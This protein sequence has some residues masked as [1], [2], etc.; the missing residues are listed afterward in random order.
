MSD[1]GTELARLMAAR[2]VGVRELAR[3]VPCNPGHISNLRSG[4][5]RP[6][7]E[8][9][10]ALDERLEA[11]GSL[12]ALVPAHERR[13][14]QSTASWDDGAAA[15]EIAALELGRLA[16]AT[17]VGTGTVER[18]ELAV[19][20][21]AIAYP[22]T[23]SAELYG[24]VRGYLSY[25]GRLLDARM[26][27]AE[28]R[29][30]LVVGG[31]LSLL[32]STTLI[33]LH[34]DQAAVAHLRTAAQLARESEH[35]EI[36]AWCLETQAWQVLTTGDYQRAADISQAA[37]R[38]AP[39]TGSAFIQATAQEGR[40][41]ARLG[42][43]AQTRGALSRVEALVSPLPMPERPE[44]HYRYDPPKAQ[45]YVATTLSWLGDKA[46]EGLARKVLAAIE[47]PGERPRPRRAALARLDLALALTAADKH[48]EAAGVTLE[49]IK[50]GRLAPVDGR[51]AREIVLAVAERGVPE[52]A[53]LAEAYQAACGD[54][55]SPPALP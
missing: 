16:E 38:I 1:F 33:D 12:C 6:S 28:H 19:D 26:T 40:A 45:V 10:E 35:T 24:R 44:H 46:A 52:A 7:A 9:A 15:D 34:R 49:A 30:L 51:R 22:S 5:A 42:A 27:L 48:D 50:S 55:G 2:G 14:P 4:K 13:S 43:A 29:L 37:Q 18:L 53:E 47:A 20:E 23:P 8:L 11:G 3:M 39:K 32:A 36:A 54:S 41:W 25:V 17:E 21:L 31:W